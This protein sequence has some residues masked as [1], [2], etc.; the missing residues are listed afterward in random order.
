MNAKLRPTSGQA[1]EAR[2]RHNYRA[3]H[4]T[5]P[6]TGV[7]PGNGPNG[8]FFNYQGVFGPAQVE[9]VNFRNIE[10]E[11]ALKYQGVRIAEILDGTA[12]TALFS[13]RLVGDENQ[14]LA[15]PKRD[16]FF[17]SAP[18]PAKSDTGPGGADDIHTRCLTLSPSTV[19]STQNASTG[20]STYNNGGLALTW[21]NH[22]SPPNHKSCGNVTASS[23]PEGF[24]SPAS[25]NDG[26]MPPTSNHP[27]GVNM[28]LCDGS[29]R[30]IRETISIQIWRNLG[31]RM[32]GNAIGQF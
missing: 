3:N 27:G 12:F 5:W 23:T 21:Y 28:V 29:T 1:T 14:L 4:G 8:I 16:T 10:P 30:F 7:S 2:T 17:L 20:G 19:P 6:S 9:G 25:I 15:T 32:D 18:N 11:L 24:G 13:E 22:T 26:S 31:N